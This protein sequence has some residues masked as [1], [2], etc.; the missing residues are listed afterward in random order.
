M[1][2]LLDPNLY[3]LL[4]STIDPDSLRFHRFMETDPTYIRRLF[5]GPRDM[6]QGYPPEP[7]NARLL[8][9]AS[10]YFTFLNIVTQCEPM[11]PANDELKRLKK[12]LQALYSFLARLLWYTGNGELTAS[13]EY[14]SAFD[15]ACIVFTALTQI[16][17]IS[18]KTSGGYDPD[19]RPNI[20]ARKGWR[21][22]HRV[23]AA[24][25][26]QRP[27][28]AEDT[29]D[30]D[31]L[32]QL[33][34]APAWYNIPLKHQVHDYSLSNPK[35]WCGMFAFWAYKRSGIAPLWNWS[36]MQQDYISNRPDI[37]TPV[38]GTPG[39]GDIGYRQNQNH[40][41]IVADVSPDNPNL[42][43]TVEGN[44]DNWSGFNCASGVWLHGPFDNSTAAADMKYSFFCLKKTHALKI[45][46]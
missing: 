12:R 14:F 22:L 29:Q 13:D 24:A 9:L 38:A 41:C 31:S 20:Q 42:I 44:S 21:M 27:I 39:I 6:Y 36:A 43:T 17:R 30:D 15:R 16:G 19:Y 8:A 11:Y 7:D 23:F 1:N 46:K 3:E 26:G 45:A 5:R 37:F 33:T 10:G 28:D 40:F 32:S 34:A 25:S 18:A 2:I 35:E 4:N